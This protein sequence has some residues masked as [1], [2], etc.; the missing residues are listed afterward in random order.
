MSLSVELTQICYPVANSLAS[1]FIQS[2]EFAY[3]LENAAF[4]PRDP[5]S[6]QILCVG[7]YFARLANRPVSFNQ[8][9]EK[10][11]EVKTDNTMFCS[12]V[13]R[14]WIQNSVAVRKHPGSLYACLGCWVCRLFT[15]CEE[16]V[17]FF[18]LSHFICTGS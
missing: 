8:A 15:S 9:E 3:W 6:G 4:L 10:C 2:P 18:I 13:Y 1:Q 5:I 16:C 14:F 12:D 7:R 11:D 17:E